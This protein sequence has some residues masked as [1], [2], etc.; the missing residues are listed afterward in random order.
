MATRE[1]SAVESGER[2]SSD[3]HPQGSYAV[4]AQGEA[5]EGYEAGKPALA[6]DV[7]GESEG[8][9]V[10]VEVSER[11]ET[12]HVNREEVNLQCAFLEVC[13]SRGKAERDVDVLQRSL[14]LFL[15][16]LFSLCGVVEKLELELSSAHK[17]TGKEKEE[18]EGVVVFR[19]VV[20]LNRCSEAALLCETLHGT[21]HELAADSKVKVKAWWGSPGDEGMLQGRATV[22]VDLDL[23]SKDEMLEPSVVEQDLLYRFT[24]CGKVES[25]RVLDDSRGAII[26]FEKASGAAKALED[27]EQRGSLLFSG[28]ALRSVDI[29][30]HSLESLMPIPELPSPLV[31][32]GLD[33]LKRKTIDPGDGRITQNSH[34][35]PVVREYPPTTGKTRRSPASVSIYSE[36]LNKRTKPLVENDNPVVDETSKTSQSYVIPPSNPANKRET[37]ETKDADQ[38]NESEGTGSSNGTNTTKERKSSSGTAGTEVKIKAPRNK[39]QNRKLTLVENVENKKIFI[40]HNDNTSLEAIDS[41]V[42]GLDGVE[43]CEVEEAS[44][45]P[46]GCT[47]VSFVSI[48]AAKSALRELRDVSVAGAA[49]QPSPQEITT[50]KRRTEEFRAQSSRSGTIRPRHD[51]QRRDISRELHKTKRVF[52]RDSQ[53]TE[54][55]SSAPATNKAKREKRIPSS[56]RGEEEKA[57]LNEP[58]STR[59]D[60]SLSPI[61]TGRRTA[62]HQAEEPA[63]S[64]DTASGSRQG[65]PSDEE[66]SKQLAVDFNSAVGLGYPVKKEDGVA[67]HPVQPY[68]HPH[69]P[70]MNAP[71]TMPHLHQHPHPQQRVPLMYSNMPM[72]PQNMQQGMHYQGQPVYGQAQQHQQHPRPHPHQHQHQHQH[73]HPHQH[74]QP[75]MPYQGMIPPAMPSW[76]VY[77]QGRY[78]YGYGSGHPRAPPPHPLENGQ[79]LLHQDVGNTAYIASAQVQ[80]RPPQRIASGA[81]SGYGDSDVPQQANATLYHKTRGVAQEGSDGSHSQSSLNNSRLYVRFDSPLEDENILREKFER[82]APDF[83]Y[84]SRHSGKTFAFVKYSTAASASLA[85]HR[86]DGVLIEGKKL[87]VSIANP[88]RPVRKRQRTSDVH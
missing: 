1:T 81:L 79:E 47:T 42:V 2:T 28:Y 5:K 66:I 11:D 25:V 65:N 13:V 48:Q 33:N 75:G 35:R 54:T 74:P 70:I 30:L 51:E 39:L 68:G 59:Q 43:S 62:N 14:C 36:K 86:L 67:P 4:A 46:R 82:A 6:V 63:P 85:L 53:S 27:V 60:S 71:R 3:K 40:V 20:Q 41:V 45:I 44:D 12:V 78:E 7:A 69:R 24:C 61:A 31:T 56:S 15:R 88:P 58:S 10:A 17:T 38:K 8:V 18:D 57:S 64:A 9:E 16:S 37:A 83:E 29:Y 52:Q 76:D 73:P 77:G 50:R 87:R 21:A 49:G 19:G 32:V 55:G 26:R 34:D 84:V 22:F 80:V 23:E 72:P